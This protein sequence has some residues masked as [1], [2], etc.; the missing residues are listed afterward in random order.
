[1]TISNDTAGD[2]RGQDGPTPTG[3]GGQDD[4]TP[5]GRRLAD[6]M[7]L[8][9]AEEKML[10]WCVA[11]AGDATLGDGKRPEP[12]APGRRIRADFIRFL[13]LGGETGTAS[14]HDNAVEVTGAWIDGIVDLGWVVARRQLALHNSTFDYISAYDAEIGLL[15]L[16]GSHLRFGLGAQRLRCPGGVFLRGGFAADGP[17][18]LGDAVL[19]QFDGSGAIFADP[20]TAD[21]KPAFVAGFAAA[22]ARQRSAKRPDPGPP[23]TQA[24]LEDRTGVADA[25]PAF[26]V[27]LDGAVI[28]GNVNL[29]RSTVVGQVLLSVA[30]MATLALQGVEIRRPGALALDLT[31]AEANAI[32]LDRSPKPDVRPAKIAGTVK[33]VWVKANALTCDGLELTDPEVGSDGADVSL[34]MTGAGVTGLLRLY[35]AARIDGRVDLT[36][37]HAGL[38]QV[39]AGPAWA[40]AWQFVL[41]GFSYDRLL[42]AGTDKL[43]GRAIGWLQRQPPEHLGKAFRPQ[44]WE[45]L[46]TVLRASGHPTDANRVAIAKQKQL[47]DAGKITGFAGAV[48]ALYGWATCYGYDP[49]RLLAGM[50]VVWLGCATIY[51]AAA[52]PWFGTAPLV[53]PAKTPDQT[54]CRIAHAVRPQVEPA[55]PAPPTPAAQAR[56][57]P[58][59]KYSAD[60]IVPAIGLGTAKEWQPVTDGVLGKALQGLTV[61]ELIIGWIGGP[62]L[63]LNV[64]GRLLKK[65]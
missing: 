31:N 50:F 47:R 52:S 13:A 35:E 37:A 48:H 10:A 2:I 11:G 59:L 39:K 51:A 54:A 21:V 38:L 23:D 49:T 15:S 55:C 30:R 8:L 24:S 33:L 34:D 26:A 6:F 42:G 56:D 62:A 64:G 40:G 20:D 9:G 61:L 14:Q 41:D 27:S 16:Q 5:T 3:A 43:S 17:V 19:G 7:P 44:P 65:D 18:D 60:L 25:L 4:P 58:A 12:G 22:K 1:M 28:A 36:Q 45:Q 53:A 63:A 46:I 29:A 57:F 32:L